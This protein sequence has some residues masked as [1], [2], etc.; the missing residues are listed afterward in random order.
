MSARLLAE[1]ALMRPTLELPAV[2]APPVAPIVDG[3]V[4]TVTVKQTRGGTQV[5]S[6]GQMSGGAYWMF[7]AAPARPLRL[8]SFTVTVSPE[9]A[10]VAV[11]AAGLGGRTSR[12][13]TR[14]EPQPQGHARVDV[15]AP[16]PL[17]LS[18]VSGP[19][20]RAG[21]ERADIFGD[22]LDPGQ[23]VAYVPLKRAPDGTS[24]LRISPRLVHRTLIEVACRP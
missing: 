6:E 10:P 9:P 15:R 3:T 21:G 8:G 1:M 24:W 4:M 13:L 23:T 22:G 2:V 20:A 16:L 12:L 14:P 18:L 7:E 19:A 17:A 5:D 11:R